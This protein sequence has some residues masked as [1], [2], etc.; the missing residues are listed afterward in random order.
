MIGILFVTTVAVLLLRW[1]RAPVRL[2]QGVSFG[3]AAFA[4]VIGLLDPG[5]RPEIPDLLAWAQALGLVSLAALPI[6]IYAFAIRRLRSRAGG[7]AGAAPA[8]PRGFVQI[9]EDSAL[10]QEVTAELA[11]E[12]AAKGIAPPTSLSVAYRDADGT[13]TASGE[14]I[15][16]QGLAEFRRLWVEPDQRGGGLGTRLLAEMEALAADRGATAAV[17]DTWSGRTERFVRA[18]GYDERGRV[19]APGGQARIW[20]SKPLS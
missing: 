9:V 2:R 11:A 18:A 8:H 17:I 7:D 10:D 6:G 3:G 5:A 16:S 14:V 1:W 4:L 13:V 19:A 12:A 15:L 20:L